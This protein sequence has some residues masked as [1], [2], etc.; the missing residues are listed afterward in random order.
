MAREITDLHGN[1]FRV[2]DYKLCLKIPITGKGNL[3]FTRDLISGEPFNLSVNKKKYKGYFY[4]LS[5]NLYVRYDLEY[6][7]YDESSDIR[8]ISFVCQKRKIR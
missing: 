1:K 2:G 7:G 4:N 5:L 8:K 3:V 6:V